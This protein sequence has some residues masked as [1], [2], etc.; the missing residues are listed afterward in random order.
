MFAYL[1][2]ASISFL[3]LRFFFMFFFLQSAG[4]FASPKFRARRAFATYAPY[5]YV[6]SPNQRVNEGSNRPAPTCRLFVEMG[7]GECSHRLA[8]LSEK[9]G[10]LYPRGHFGKMT[11]PRP[12][13]RVKHAIVIA[14]AVF[15][16]IVYF[17]GGIPISGICDFASY[18][19]RFAE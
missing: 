8:Y 1:A 6:N 10:R 14:H 17:R 3:L 15:F 5:C 16:L 12:R 19:C 11:S 9:E 4:F 18:G 2:Q 7:H 13:R